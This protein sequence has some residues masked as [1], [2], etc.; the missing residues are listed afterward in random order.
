MC[1]YIVMFAEVANIDNKLQIINTDI[2]GLF[3][4]NL[5]IRYNAQL[6][7][8]PGLHWSRWWRYN[9]NRLY[10]IQQK[11]NFLRLLAKFCIIFLGF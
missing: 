1:H 4:E 10:H 2:V 7:I 11:F 6:D 8:P 3:D 5:L 9:G